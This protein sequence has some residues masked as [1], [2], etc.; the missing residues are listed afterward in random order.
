MLKSQINRII[1]KKLVVNLKNH[2]Y[3]YTNIWDLRYQEN[4]EGSNSHGTFLHNSVAQ[5]RGRPVHNRKLIHI[6]I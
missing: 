6:N 1:L 5:F 4:F 3:I 2:N